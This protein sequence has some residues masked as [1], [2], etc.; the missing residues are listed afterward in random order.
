MALRDTNTFNVL[1]PAPATMLYNVIGSFSISGQQI[2]VSAGTV[3][4]FFIKLCLG[5]AVS[6]TF[7]KVAWRAINFKSAKVGTLDEENSAY[8]AIGH[9]FLRCLI[10][11]VNAGNRRVAAGCFIRYSSYVDGPS[12]LYDEVPQVDFKSLNFAFL[13][14]ANGPSSVFDHAG[15]QYPVQR[16]VSATLTQGEILLISLPK[17]SSFWM[18]DFHGPAVKCAPVNTTWHRQIRE[19]IFDMT[20]S[21]DPPCGISYGYISWVPDASSPDGFLPFT[22]IT[23]GGKLTL[24]LGTLGL[25]GEAFYASDGG[26]YPS[27]FPALSFLVA[28]FPSM[29]TGFLMDSCALEAPAFADLTIFQCSLFNALY[30]SNYSY[31]NEV[32]NISTSVLLPSLNSVGYLGGRRRAHWRIERQWGIS[33]Q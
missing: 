11:I 25:Q 15:P 27:S 19:N 2:D 9:H 20:N 14:V 1:R 23:A 31:V 13:P 29:D 21:T 33:P 28:V 5:F 8:Y 16:V 32:Q 30:V 4:A 24:R 7:A 6:T 10:D 18:L 3:L 17:T 12:S 26:L 22:T